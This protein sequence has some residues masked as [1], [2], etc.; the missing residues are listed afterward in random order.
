MFANNF[1]VSNSFEF[2]KN[3]AKQLTIWLILQPLLI[4]F[5]FKEEHAVTA[6]LTIKKKL[7]NIF[8]FLFLNCTSKYQLYITTYSYN[9]RCTKG[10]E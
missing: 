2:S 8:S 1:V 9:S 4:G 6:K 7:F 3:V 5:Y 10:V